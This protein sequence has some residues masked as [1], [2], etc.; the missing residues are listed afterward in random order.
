MLWIDGGGRTRD[1]SAEARETDPTV[2]WTRIRG[3]SILPPPSVVLPR[4]ERERSPSPPYPSI[5]M[6][7]SVDPSRLRWSLTHGLAVVLGLGLGLAAT[8]AAAH[9]GSGRRIH[10]EVREGGAAL[11]VE[12][13]ATAAG[14]ALGL[15]TAF[16]EAALRP[17]AA[18]VQRWVGGGLRLEG[19]GGPCLATPTTPTLDAEAEP[20]RVVVELDYACPAPMGVMHLHDDTVADDDATHETLVS[21]RDRDGSAHAH[22]LRAGASHV[23]LGRTPPASE[24][25]AAFVVQGGLHL[26]T[27]YDHMLFLLSLI[28]AAGL[29]V[30]RQGMRP[31]LRDVAWVVTAFT[32]GHSVSLC[33]AALGWVSLPT[34]AVEIAIAGSIVL[35]ALGNVFRP[36]ASVARP[37]LAGAFGVVHGFGFSSV[38]AELGLPAAHRVLALVSFNVGIELAQLAFVAVVLVPLARLAQHDGYQRFVLQGASL[39]IAACGGLWLVER[40]APSMGL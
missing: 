40:A 14:V 13:D 23:E 25:A 36:E 21:V 29:V 8:S 19:E 27:G 6:R 26:V 37:W 2:P 5:A 9:A 38:L 17:H 15:G 28:L 34:T 35:V 30:R 24:T 7:P 32:L 20:A 4:T 31:A 3:A 11:R 12:V 39:V 33:A 16:D 18:L 10:A 22:V 1:F